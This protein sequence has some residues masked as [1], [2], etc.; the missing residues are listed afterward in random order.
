MPYSK[1]K[2]IAEAARRGASCKDGK[3]HI[4]LLMEGTGRPFTH[5]SA[6][7]DDNYFKALCK[8]GGWEPLDFAQAISGSKKSRGV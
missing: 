6:E 2:V 8:W 3:K 1:K 4:K 7:I 5:S